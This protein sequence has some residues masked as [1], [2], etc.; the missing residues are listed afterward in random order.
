VA[1]IIERPQEHFL[2]LTLDG[3]GCLIEK[4]VM[5]IGTLNQTVVHPREVFCDAISDRAAGIVLVHNH[6]SGRVEP[7]REDT[8]ITERLVRVGR[9]VGIEVVD[10]VIVGRGGTFSFKAEGMLSE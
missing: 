7:S 5:F 9:L 6:P 4:R 2:T 10:H 3:G 8:A 1:E